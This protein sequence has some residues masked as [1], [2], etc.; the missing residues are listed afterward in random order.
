MH[1]KRYW[2]LSLPPRLGCVLLSLLGTQLT[3]GAA[4]PKAPPLILVSL[5]GFRAD[6]FDRYPCPVLHSLSTSGVRAREMEPVF[7]SLTFPNH[8]TM[9]TG[10]YPEHH[11]IVSNE[12]F[13]PQRQKVFHFKSKSDSIDPEWWSGGEPLWISLRKLN[14]VANL[15]YWVGGLAPHHGMTANYSEGRFPFISGEARVDEVL[16]RIAPTQNHD[17]AAHFSTLYL[18]MVDEAGHSFGPNS[19]KVAS[20]IEEVDSLLG[21]LVSGLQKKNA[22]ASTNVVVVSDHGMTELSPA[23]THLLAPDLQNYPSVKAIGAG[24]LVNLYAPKATLEP[25]YATLLKHRNHYQVWKREEIPERFHYRQSARI[26]DL[27]L[28]ADLGW[29]LLTRPTKPMLHS[30]KE[31]AAQRKPSLPMKGAHGYDNENKEMQALFVAHGPS[32]LSGQIIEKLRTV[33]LYSV[34]Q[35]ALEQ[36][37]LVATP[38]PDAQLSKKRELTIFSPTR[39]IPSPKS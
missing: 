30:K 32:F 38:S 8:Y 1:K 3:L 33:E 28:L 31:A 16:R 22:W 10:L 34:L 7:P 24:A 13:D 14:L 35:T 25:L 21:R 5:D 37:N 18:E 19:P 39:H 29:Y 11:G 12:F 36:S 20:A 27:V 15:V 6:Y 17:V 2:R 26:G 9:V 23:R 4:L